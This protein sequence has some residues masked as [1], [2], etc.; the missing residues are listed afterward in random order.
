MKHGRPGFAFGSVLLLSATISVAQTTGDIEG[1]VT[2]MDG[3]PLPGVTIEAMS[4]SLQGVR[5]EV[6][7]REGKYRILAVPPGVY[8]IRASLEGFE[9]AEETITLALDKTATLDLKLKMVVKAAIVVTGEVPLVDVTST[10]AGTNYTNRVIV[11]LPVNRNYAD[12]VRSNPG[13]NSDQGETQ[14]RS[15]A[16]TIYGATSAENQWIVDGSNTTNVVK[17]MQG[18]AI[19]NEFVQEMEVK[20]GGYQAEY[21][22][23]MGGIINV[24]TKSGGNEFH[25]DGFVYYDSSSWQAAR[26]ATDQDS[27]V[28]F[29]RVADYTRT[30]FGADIGGYFLKDRLWFFGAYDRVQT[31]A[32][33]SRYISSQLVPNTLEFPLDSTDSLYAGKLTWNAAAGT[34]FVATVFADPTLNAGAGASDPRQGRFVTRVISNPDP[35]TWSADRHIGGVD[36]SLRAMQVFGSTSFMALQAS[37]HEDS[38]EL[39]PSGGASEPILKDRTCAG[40][41]PAKPCRKPSTDNFATGGFGLVFGPINRNTS[42]RAQVRG[43]VDLYLREHEFKV[44][45]DYQDAKTLAINAFTGGQRVFRFNERGQTYYQHDFYSASPTDL[46]P[47]DNPVNPRTTDVGVYLQDSWRLSRGVTVNAGVRWDQEAIQ[48]YRREKVIQTSL[49]Q[50]R[51]GIVWDPGKDGSTKLYAFAGRFGYAL[52]TDLSVRAY[53]AQTVASTYNFDPVSLTQDPSVIGHS[54]PVIQGGAFSEPVDSHLKAIYQDELT[55]GA[56][57]LFGPSFSVGIKATYRRLGNA[58]EDRCDLDYNRP[59]TNYNGCGIINPG[60]GEPI[61]R[62]DLPGCNGLDGDFFACSDTSPAIGPARRLYRG[63]EILAR[64]SFQDRL[65]L[66]ASYVFSSLRG[67]YDGEVNASGQTDPGI[68]ADFDVPAMLHNDY[69]RLFLDRPHSFRLDGFYTAPFGLSVGVQAYARSGAPLDKRGYLGGGGWDVQLVPRGYAGREGTNWD[70]NLTLAYPLAIGPAA[71]T[72]QAYVFNVFNNQF[73]TSQDV[74]WSTQA[75]ADYPKSLYD[76]NQEQNN[77]EYGKILSRQD[78]RLFRAAIRLS[79]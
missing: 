10:T 45:G 70:A 23:A 38:Y 73:A 6:T 71:V 75:P 50:P 29:M 16:L 68:N 54:K 25:G 53:G 74:W 78:P 30:D 63:I 2:D 36:Y 35:A 77:S 49:W 24:I 39:K 31:P 62:G 8:R 28:N 20:T 14:G 22:R 17:G 21:G 19:N 1:T 67:N 44:G 66:Q 13:V 52:P 4:P 12:I 76:P 18:K 40:G 69:G 65:W 48:D 27:I 15:I 61:A 26:K 7:G 32:K 72:L 33:V 42:T 34:S 46:T 59:E 41:T 60:S 57:K 11:R 9:K 51:L 3:T 37:R 79:F 64:K 56:D 43:D 58:I 55:I 47:V 5:V